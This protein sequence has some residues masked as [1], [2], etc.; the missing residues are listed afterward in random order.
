MRPPV[1]P[2]LIHITPDFGVYWYGTLIVIG[3]LLGALY[4]A[5]RANQNGDD[6]DHIWNGLTFAIILGIIGARLYHV[7][8]E[9]QG[10]MVGWSY[11]RQNPIEILYLWRGGLGIYGAIVGGALGAALY[12]WRRQLRPLKWLDYG[13]AGLA[14]GQAI[15]RWGN[16][17]NQELYG[18]PTDLPWGLIIDPEHRI[19]PYDDLSVYPPDTL[20]HPTFL[21]ESLWCLLL[22][23][24][25][26]LISRRWKDRLLEG[27]ILLG[28]I[29]G[30][31]LGR[32]F[33]EFLR[34]DAWML[35]PLAAAQLFAIICVVG[36]VALLIVRHATARRAPPEAA[37]A[38]TVPAPDEV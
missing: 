27:D 20:F 11:Y 2:I 9:P 34:P 14:L 7:I 16:F 1:D 31:P 21:Y 22:F 3:I 10:G 36:G 32:F 37:D 33:V 29:I 28:Y 13:A 35:G 38:E 8:S 12:A 26:A 24:T 4:A 6:P 23:V 18:P 30:Y 17:I 25:L 19:V 15:G 5:W